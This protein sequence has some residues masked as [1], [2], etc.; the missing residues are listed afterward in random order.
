MAELAVGAP[1]DDD[2]T[3]SA[4]QNRGSVW[5]LF[6]EETGVVK[7]SQKISSINGNFTGELSGADHF[8]CSVTAISDL[9]GDNVNELAVGA[10]GDDDGSSNSG[11]VWVLFMNVSTISLAYF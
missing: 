1:K 9:D 4:G 8:G 10:Y 5:I 6:L 2:R 3:G 7:S 11:A